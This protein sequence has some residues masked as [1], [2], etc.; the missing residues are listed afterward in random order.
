MK[1]HKEKYEELTLRF[2]KELH[3]VGVTQEMIK[4]IKAQCARS[5]NV[6]SVNTDETTDRFI[7]RHEGYVIEATRNVKIVIRTCK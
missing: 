1:M 3:D 7:Y 5:P 2:A 6:A 4:L